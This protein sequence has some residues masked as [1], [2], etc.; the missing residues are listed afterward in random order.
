MNV[1]SYLFAQELDLP[2]KKSLDESVENNLET[3]ENNLNDG[4]AYLERLSYFREHPTNLNNENDINLQEIGLLNPLL[5]KAIVDYKN[6]LGSFIS[7]YELQAIP[8]MSMEKIKEM[9]PYVMVS[10]NSTSFDAVKKK[11]YFW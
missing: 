1:T 9:L 10:G 4:T 11:V 7:I 8:G 6:L 5:I 2:I 3:D